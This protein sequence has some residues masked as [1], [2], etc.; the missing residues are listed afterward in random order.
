MDGDD[1]WSYLENNLGRLSR[2]L[3]REHIEHLVI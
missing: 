2:L 1:L 3:I